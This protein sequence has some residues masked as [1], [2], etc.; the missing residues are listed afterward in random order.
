MLGVTRSRR[1]QTAQD[2][3]RTQ[4]HRREIRCPHGRAHGGGAGEVSEIHSSGARFGSEDHMTEIMSEEKATK[5]PP[6]TLDEALD[7]FWKRDSGSDHKPDHV[8]FMNWIGE[9]VEA[10]RAEP[11][12]PIHAMRTHAI[13]ELPFELRLNFEAAAAA[14]NLGIEI[15]K[16]GP[17]P[18]RLLFGKSSGRP[19]LSLIRETSYSLS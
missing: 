2:R 4:D 3:P 15:S 8:G 19:N 18:N 9:K 1:A 12:V 17:V 6:E 5:P 11:L 14:K 10:S 7:R 13:T 16:D